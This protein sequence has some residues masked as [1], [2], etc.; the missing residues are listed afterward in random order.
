[1][2]V[3][4]GWIAPWLDRMDRHFDDRGFNDSG[5]KTRPNELFRCNRWML[6]K[7]VE[8]TPRYWR[9]LYRPEQN[10]IGDDERIE[11]LSPLARRQVLAGG[12]MGFYGLHR[13]CPAGQKGSTEAGSI[14]PAA[15]SIAV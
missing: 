1:V 5:L 9:G 10:H 2:G 13:A 11:L 3:G 15:R 8:G 14:T 6:F 7:P 4:R 12:A